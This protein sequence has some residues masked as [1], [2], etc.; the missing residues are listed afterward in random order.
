MKKCRNIEFKEE[1][2]NTFLKTVSAYANFGKGTVYF[3]IKDD[4]SVVGF[5]NPERICLDIENKINDSIKPRPTF[6][7]NVNKSNGVIALVVEE[8]SFKPYLYKGKAYKRNDTATIEVD[9]V[10]LRR[11]VLV[12]ENLYFES[13]SIEE[14]DLKFT[15]LFEQ[16]R[17]KMNIERPDIDILKTLGLYTAQNSYN[18]AALLVSDNN[19]FPGIDIVKF[20]ESLNEILF[21]ETIANDSILSL[22]ERAETVFDNYY[23]VEE[24][25]G[26]ERKQKY[27]VPKEAFRESIA[28]A[29]IHR[30]WDIDSKIRIMMHKDAIEIYSPGGLPAGISK[31]EYM[32]GFVSSLRNP[33]IANVFFRLNIVEMFGTGIRRIKESYTDKI[34]KPSF[35]VMENSI[36]VKLPSISEKHNIT[37]DEKKIIGTLS[38]GIWLGSSEIANITGFSKNKVIRHVNALIDKKYIVKENSGPGTKYRCL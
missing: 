8:G 19:T 5:E 21:R 20:G 13:L 11:L 4:G 32:N 9:Q 36:V 26:I 29:L 17:R 10:E 16:L 35:E 28:N 24:I 1:V 34:G 6:S 33:V 14:K 3:G 7:F 2:A 12:G 37:E 38:K 31:E 15:C 23:K 18:N 30:T 22:L 27:L 25:I